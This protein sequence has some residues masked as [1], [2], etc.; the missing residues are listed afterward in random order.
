MLAVWIVLGVGFGFAVGWFT[1]GYDDAEIIE[2]LE[3]DLEAARRS[4]RRETLENLRWA[5]VKGIKP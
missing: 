2:H 1:R 5:M 3:Q 4:A